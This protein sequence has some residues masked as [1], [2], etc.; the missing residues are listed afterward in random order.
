MQF[1]D[2]DAAGK[3]WYCALFDETGGDVCPEV[4]AAHPTDAP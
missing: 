3:R 2:L 4:A 1:E